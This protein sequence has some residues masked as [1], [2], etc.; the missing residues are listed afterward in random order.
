VQVTRSLCPLLLAM[1]VHA[2]AMMSV[3]FIL[4]SNNIKLVSVASYTISWLRIVLELQL[5]YTWN[6]LLKCKHSLMRTFLLVDRLETWHCRYF[7]YLCNGKMRQNWR[8]PYTVSKKSGTHILL[9]NY[10]K[11]GPILIILLLSHSQ[12]NCSKRL[13]NI[14]HLTSN[15]L[16]YRPTTM[17]KLNVQ[18][19]YG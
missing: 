6:S 7:S 1:Q 3:L 5:D 10:R 16:P 18:L 13:N 2:V 12:M 11:C 4:C 9:P 15:L 19:C 8:R 17:P 14:Y